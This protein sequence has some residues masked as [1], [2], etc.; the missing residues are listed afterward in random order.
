MLKTFMLVAL[1]SFKKNKLSTSINAIGL[2]LGFSTFVVLASFVYNEISYDRWH[3]KSARIYRF[4]TIDEAIGVSSN[5][6]AITNPRMPQAAEEEIPEVEIASRMIYAGEQRMEKGDVGYY[7]EH[8]LYVENDFFEIF[9]L[10]VREREETLGKF[11]QPH[12]LILTEAYAEKV[13]GDEGSVG[14]ILTINDQSWEVV[15]LMDNI[16]QNSHLG[17]DALMS[18][19]PAQSDSSLAQYINGWG[20]LGMLGYAVLSEGADELEV[21]KKMADIALANDVNDFWVPQLQ[22]LEEIHLGSAGLLFDY[23]HQNKGDQ[24]YVYALSGVAIFILLIA[25]FNFVNLT[26][27][28]S[29]T[30]AK[31][32]GIRKVVGSS[33][34][35]L[36]GQ[37]MIE[38]ILLATM[39][40]VISL[41]LVSML[42]NSNSLN[43]NFDLL[44]LMGN[45][46]ILL[47]AFLLLGILIGTLAGIYP[48]FI[49][50]S[51]KSVNI[52]RG[53]FQT[54]SKGI[55]LRKTLVVLQFVA[56]IG[57]IC[58]TLIVSKQ[59]D[60]IKN[61]HLGF[62]KDQV[63]NINVGNPG[64][65]SGMENFKESLDNYSNVISTGYSNNMPGNTFGRGGVNVEGGNEDEPWI[66]SVMS[67]DENYLDAMGMELAAGRNYDPSFGA[68]QQESI[69][70]NEAMMESLGWDE[71]V[72]KNLVFGNNT[73]RKVVGVIKDFHF[74]SM[75]HKIEPLMIYYN[76][77]P[78]NNLVLKVSPTNVRETLDFLE[79][80][81]NATFPNYPFDYQFFDQEFNQIFASDE[82]FARLVNTFTLLSIVLSALG[83]FGLSFFM[84][85]QRKKEIGVRKVLG[86]TV[87][88]IVQ[89]LMKEFVI[90]IIL[91]NVIAWPI[92]FYFLK[93]WISDFQYRIDLWGI[94]NLAIY[95][96][97]GIGALLVAMIAVSYKSIRAAL[98]NP[99]NSLRDE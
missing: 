54:S 26:T 34:A 7:S 49:L 17:F 41:F 62:E 33:K 70:I 45:S 79:A 91:A 30:R 68:D 90:L 48:S 56:A 53:K 63:I 72:G 66:V 57:M 38:S 52:L 96:F 88:Q 64:L 11:N 71:A 94:D 98:S 43:L 50:S 81:W 77:G 60:Y 35:L 82:L 80:E 55:W 32:V 27:A 39:A 1:R 3:E 20:G 28:Q 18:L 59:I 61:K 87:R 76:P 25:A 31:E 40:M 2:I 36:I 75:R 29:T 84:V 13:F 78:N 24:V 10:P 14:Q 23:Y 19:Y 4:T 93:G 9:D 21:E 15:G 83:L 16:T 5:E 97:A 46:P 86:S 22:P 69:I 51:I 47:P 37:H 67:M 74:S 8:A 92:A 95:L 42:T 12:K 73:T 44:T 6:V 99:V 89:L 58:T 85:E 65:A